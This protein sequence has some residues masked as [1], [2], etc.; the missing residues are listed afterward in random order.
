MSEAREREA[1]LAQIAAAWPVRSAWLSA[2]A[3][4]G[5][6]R[7]LTNRVARLLL[8][9]TAPG[10]ILCLTFTKAAAAEMQNRLFKQLGTWAMMPDAPLRA[11]LA[12]LGEE[13]LPDAQLLHARSLFARA[14][15]TP[16]GLKI[17][18][19]HA[20]CESL[21]HRFPLEAQVAPDFELLDERGAEGLRREVLD[22][23]ALAMP[24]TYAEFIEK[25]GDPAT[26]L[27]DILK[28]QE[29]FAQAFYEAEAAEVIGAEPGLEDAKILQG[30]FAGI[31]DQDIDRL[32]EEMLAN[33]NKHEVRVARALRARKSDPVAAVL[34]MLEAVFLTD[35]EPRKTTRFPVKAVKEAFPPALD[36]VSR[37]IER[38]Y[39]ARQQR[40]ALLALEKARLLHGFA[41][42]FLH[43]YN[44]RKAAR[45]VL[46]FEDLI[47]KADA[48]L[49]ESDMA[50]WV[51]YRLDGGIDHILVDEAQDTSPLQWDIIKALAEEIYA[52]AA[53]SGPQRTIFVVGDEKQ[54]IFSFQ[55]ADPRAFS[56]V[57][58]LLHERLAA[59]QTPMFEGALHYS[60]RSAPPILALV[61]KVFGGG[62][63][64]G[65]AG[66]I[67]HK[68][69]E[70]ARPGR[71]ELWPFYENQAKKDALPWDAPVD[72]LPPG[73]PV[74]LL[75]GDVAARVA[76]IIAG[77]QVLPGKDRPVQAG[78]FL[79]LVQSRGAL[80]RALLKEL[81]AR[82]VPV[83][84]ADR[85]KVAEELAVKDLLALLQFAANPED[86]LALASALR[87]PLCGVSEAALFRLAHG[88]AGRLWAEVR[89]DAMLSD[90]LEHVDYSRPFELL[91]RIL[92]HHKGR[93]KLLARLGPEAEEGVDELLRLALEYE[94]S[95]APSLTGFLDWVR[96]DELEV[97]RQFNNGD[98]LLRIMTVHGAKGLEAP[99]VILPQTVKKPDNR[100][101][102]VLPLGDGLATC[103]AGVAALPES[104][105]AARQVQKDLQAG[106]RARLLY[107]ALTR[108]ES[109]LIMAGCGDRKQAPE[110]WYDLAA[111]A[112]A[113]LG[114]APREQGRLVLENNWHPEQAD[115]QNTEENQEKAAIAVPSWLHRPA[116]AV[117]KPPP[118]RS[119]S[120]LGGAHTVS[121]AEPAEGALMRGTQIHTLLEHLAGVPERQRPARAQA[122]LEAPLEGVIEEALKVLKT[123][124]LADIFAADTL[125]EVP[126]AATLPGIGPIAGR[127]DALRIGQAILAVDFKSNPQV[128]VRPEDIPEGF[129]RQ[130][131]AYGA[132]LALVYPGREIK[133]AILWTAGQSLMEVPPHMRDAALKRAAGA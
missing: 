35:G 8:G 125:R 98:N 28:H 37:F 80:F 129:V 94:Q 101:K 43:R 14:L 127:I 26:F 48:L 56:S 69:V 19:I 36:L 21:L 75:A 112:L 123:P 120:D 51:L 25:A 95:E 76:E 67:S 45:G 115:P 61:D 52:A 132:A 7:V 113:A 117:G 66:K 108:A 4:S 100:G 16:G 55:G 130:M 6:T 31:P 71:V 74:L 3:G 110:N 90:I 29:L 40:L 58:A 46:E 5:K 93:E 126:V 131:A 133:T 77:K 122:L 70:E 87:S 38:V 83:A 89:P 30:L 105:A 22:D 84:G 68:A 116:P 49:R 104:L 79:I 11:A 10:R 103:G 86:D 20:F 59:V 114:A 57:K 53:E 106:E 62:L 15:E 96:A 13:A 64:A 92:I 41:S 121:G 60:F 50:Q 47:R 82:E 118:A 128:P 24:D 34:D 33:A 23:M 99:I 78:D 97:K 109:W 44:A 12:E 88:R 107:V 111:E 18:T 119:P 39:A 2:N 63:D 85:L 72:A 1:T 17:Q 54:S 102:A 65:V 42:G 91:Q 73:D 81:K 32:A 27:P 9:G 124:A